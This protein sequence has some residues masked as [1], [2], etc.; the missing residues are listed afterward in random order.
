[1]S[2][3]PSL[4]AALFR[5]R[6]TSRFGQ[7]LRREGV[8]RS[9]EFLRIAAIPARTLEGS[10]DVDGLTAMCRV[11]GGTFSLRPDQA[12]A[13]KEMVDLGGAFVGMDVSAGKSLIILLGALLTGAKRPLA[14]M[15]SAARK[16]F[17][18]IEIP[19]MRR[20]FRMPDNLMIASYEQ[21]SSK[22][23]GRDFLTSR[24]PDWI[25]ADEADALKDPDAARTARF[26]RYFEDF[27]DTRLACFSGSFLDRTIKAF[28]HLLR[29]CLREN[30]P[31]PL[32]DDALDEWASCV[33]AGVPADERYGPGALLDF[34]SLLSPEVVAACR[35]EQEL[36]L[37]A[38][39]A[40]LV[41]CPGVVFS[42]EATT[43]TAIHIRELPVDV[44][45]AVKE[46]FEVLRDTWEN[47]RG[48][49]IADAKDLYRAVR[50]LGQGFF[51]RWV[52]PIVDGK[53]VPDL[54]WID[55]RR[56]LG[57]AVRRKIAYSGGRFDT[58]GEVEDAC[59][60]HE[61]YVLTG[62]PDLKDKPRFDCPEWR[63]WKQVEHRYKPVT[64]TVWID[65]FLVHRV[66]EWLEERP[67]I[68]WVESAAM[69]EA[70]RAAGFR[71]YAGGE[72]E[73]IHERYS[74]AAAIKA[75][76]F[77]KNLQHFDRNL[78]VTPP[79]RGRTWQQLIGRTDRTGQNAR[80]IAVDLF[81][82][83]REFWGSF[84]AARHDAEFAAAPGTRQKIGKA[85][86]TLLT[87]DEQCA[88]KSFSEDPLWRYSK[89]A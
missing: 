62:D 28:A 33:D 87:S 59:K 4:G 8:K 39:G 22:K 78:I 25:F 42:T 55:A 6:A 68:A 66:A 63:V 54:I 21:L 45:K 9:A 81:L 2:D 37:K 23:N 47:P 19:K 18:E 86:I 41:S 46:A 5:P 88:L 77:A 67:G 36:G 52:W 79:T 12:Y 43:S 69:G 60:R 44:P 89:A 50:Q 10:I 85:Q 58:R 26:L 32:T 83:V 56:N 11:P 16:G 73:I 82:H 20:H 71:Y 48:D 15:P 75:H 7:A 84:R 3:A 72:N 64:E 38:W 34:A 13:L 53:E 24:M 31:L 27:P 49:V 35:D 17:E 14:I 74:C 76:S 1:M 65:R 29:L 70:I 30:S 40:K 61:A 80:L 51:Y 57:R